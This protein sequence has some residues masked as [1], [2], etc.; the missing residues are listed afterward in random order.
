M[1]KLRHVIKL[2][3]EQIRQVFPLSQPVPWEPLLCVDNLPVLS[4]CWETPVFPG[5]WSLGAA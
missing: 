5:S 1:L 3:P 4:G 2:S